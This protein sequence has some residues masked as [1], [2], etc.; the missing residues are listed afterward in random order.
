LVV[1]LK[2]IN[3]AIKKLS[4]AHAKSVG[5]TSKKN[6]SAMLKARKVPVKARL[7]PKLPVKRLAKALIKEVVVSGIVGASVSGRIIRLL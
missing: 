7:P 6:V 5:T 2:K 4:T 3:P 1:D